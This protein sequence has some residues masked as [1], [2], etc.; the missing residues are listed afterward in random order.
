MDIA[1]EALDELAPA[2]VF[3]AQAESAEASALLSEEQRGRRRRPDPAR[4][5]MSWEEDL[6]RSTTRAI[7]STVREVPPLQLE[8]ATDELGSP[9]LTWIDGDRAAALATWISTSTRSWRAA[10]LCST[11]GR[12]L[13]RK[14]KP[15]ALAQASCGS[16]RRPTRSLS[17]GGTGLK[18]AG[19]HFGVISHGKFIPL[20]LQPS[21]A[22]PLGAGIAF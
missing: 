17:P 3:G 11:T 16:A 4:G 21:R 9:A 5:I 6:I 14:T 22:G 20:P 8:S 18:S 15:A 7:A 13:R 12:R 1:G 19:S 2:A 10:S